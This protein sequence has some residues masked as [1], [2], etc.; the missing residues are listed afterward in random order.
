MVSFKT[1]FVSNHFLMEVNYTI[2]GSVD[3]TTSNSYLMC[4]GFAI[5]KYT[6]MNSGSFLEWKILSFKEQEGTKLRLIPKTIYDLFL[7][8]CHYPLLVVKQGIQFLHLNANLVIRISHRSLNV[9]C[10][11]LLSFIFPI[12]PHLLKAEVLSTQ[13]HCQDSQNNQNPLP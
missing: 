12:F 1:I 4:A 6:Q 3:T 10:P 13:G 2:T 11:F 9:I 8:K 7:T 5:V